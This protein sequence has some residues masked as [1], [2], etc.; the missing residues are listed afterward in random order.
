MTFEAVRQG[1]REGLLSHTR[2]EAFHHHQ[3][4]LRTEFLSNYYHR[5]AEEKTFTDR[6]F[7]WKARVGR[8]GE[9]V[10]IC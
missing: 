10:S 3:N 5:D 2:R 6:G 4:L 9:S 1:T 8:G 7:H